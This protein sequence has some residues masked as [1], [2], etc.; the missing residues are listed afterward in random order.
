MT[1]VGEQYQLVEK[2]GGGSFGTVYRGVDRF[3]GEPVALK[4]EFMTAK[5][6]QLRYEAAALRRLATYPG[7][8]RYY[9]LFNA[10]VSGRRQTVLA[11]EPLGKSLETLWIAC[12]RRFTLK[13]V[14]QVGIQI[15]ERIRA[16]HAASL[17]HRDVKPA[18]FVVG[19]DDTTIYAIDFGLAKRYRDPV[20]HVH[21]PFREK[22]HM[23][24]TPRYVSVNT[25]IGIEQS[26]RDDLE[27]V[28]YMLVQLYQGRLP[29]QGSKG[30]TTTEK[31]AKILE[32]K[33]NTM[34]DNLCAG[35]PPEFVRY[36]EYVKSLRFSDK[37]DYDYIIGL[38]R[39]AAGEVE[40]DGRMDWHRDPLP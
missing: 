31:Y 27:S 30:A 37:P 22:K 12:G 39:A 40:L 19:G 29:W 35:M 6:P 33:L 8:P 26:R 16:I 15:V 3:T 34:I 7:F 10:K 1:F 38:L 36:F 4:L 28:G 18:N 17:L 13:T 9:N 11:M 2:L 21:I 32:G 25:H 23:L 5:H 20:T 14:I 24:G